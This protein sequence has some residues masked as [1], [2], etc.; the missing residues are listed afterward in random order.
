MR[1]L[2][3]IFS[4][5][6]AGCPRDGAER[7]PEDPV[8]TAVSPRQ[9]PRTGGTVVRIEGSGFS[10]QPFVTLGGSSVEDFALVTADAI[11]I[12]APPDVVGPAALTVVNAEGGRTTI[13]DAF[14]YAPLDARSFD[15]R[16]FADAPDLPSANPVVVTSNETI[17]GLDVEVPL[18]VTGSIEGRVTALG[19]GLSNVT[20]SAQRAG[21]AP[22]FFPTGIDGEYAI[23]GLAPGAYRVQT[24]LPRESD[25]V[26]EAWDD[27]VDSNLGADV[28]VS[29]GAASQGIDF[30]LAPGG[31][32]A[33]TITGGGAG[34]GGVTVYAV[35][36][37]SNPLQFA[38]ATTGTDG[39]FSLKGL[40]PGGYR[41]IAFAF[42]TG[43]VTE[44]WPDALDAANAGVVTVTAGA[45]SDASMDLAEAGTISG[46]VVEEPAF[47]PLPQVIVIA[48]DVDRAIEHTS[49][50]GVD[51]T[52]RLSLPAGNYRVRAPEIGQWLG[53]VTSSSGSPVLTLAAGQVLDVA[54]FSGR[55]GF[56][57]CGDPGT[58]SVSGAVTGPGGAKILRA[59]AQL[60]PVNGGAFAQA[61]SGLDGNFTADCV[62]PG[63]Y[64]VRVVAPSS[65]LVRATWP[66]TLVVTSGGTIAG[67]D[68]S[69][70]RGA[71]LS[72]HVRDAA[73]HVP[74]GGVPVRAV[75][76]TTGE[77]RTTATAPDGSWSIDRT[78][79]G[80]LVPASYAV[81]I[82]A[83]VQS[84][85]T[86]P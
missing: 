53:G 60:L 78:S 35:A 66:V 57:P 39:A 15:G 83:H 5:T 75:S 84:E 61:T 86:P 24:A 56:A 74:L 22:V 70:A 48:K 80:G 9:G 52:F 46:S 20:M 73:T 59:A 31:S 69:L 51:G 43:R 2:L 10:T 19:A 72:G 28:I 36:T 49:A 63:E 3:L 62:A 71:K 45:A 40:A 55:L 8:V 21:A 65:D 25:L 81:E 12:V 32:I 82:R 30:D 26:D 4:L 6:I 1:R 64:S 16:W 14:F 18:A 47:G 29:A 41:V 54:N 58:G 42:G 37:P 23:R 7:L 67:I 85:H 44:Y 27:A 68:V 76:L 50:T 79:L 77:S 34:L 33:G 38:Y 11:E 17:A 13:L